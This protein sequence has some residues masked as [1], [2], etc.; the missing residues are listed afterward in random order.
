MFWFSTFGIFFGGRENVAGT[1]N[2]QAKILN[3]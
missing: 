1:L 2:T 3:S